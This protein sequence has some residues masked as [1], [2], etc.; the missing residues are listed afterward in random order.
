MDEGR[1]VG[2]LDPNILK[3]FTLCVLHSWVLTNNDIY[4]IND[5]YDK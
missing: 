5:K 4:D 3:G 1:G 2:K